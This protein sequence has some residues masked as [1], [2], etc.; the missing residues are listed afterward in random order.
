[1]NLHV[2]HLYDIIDTHFSIKEIRSGISILKTDIQNFYS[3]PLGWHTRHTR[4]KRIR[5]YILQKLFCHKIHLL[6]DK[7]ILDPK[8]AIHNITHFLAKK[9]VLNFYKF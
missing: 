6:I 3:F 9:Q 1:M 5:P 7:N 4:E 8:N 2:S